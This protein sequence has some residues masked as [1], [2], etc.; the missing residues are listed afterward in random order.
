MTLISRINVLIP[1]AG[2]GT[3][4]GL[5]YPKTLFKIDG[6]E[7]LLRILELVESYD[8]EPTVVVSPEGK[9]L[10]NKFIFENKKK[11]DVVIQEST[12]GMGNA[13]LQYRKSPKFCNSRRDSC[14]NWTEFCRNFKNMI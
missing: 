8:P 1:A 7:I 11:V 5:S 12:L 4:S 13:I 3:R 10:I 9:D 6:K 2:K 14:C